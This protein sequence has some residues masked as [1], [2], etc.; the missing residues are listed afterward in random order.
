MAGKTRESPSELP[1]KPISRR[2]LLVAFAWGFSVFESKNV[3]T[4][5][6]E[7]KKCK[8]GDATSKTRIEESWKW[9]EN[10]VET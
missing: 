9:R 8:K 2:G 6:D 10:S 3:A 1:S 5:H 7:T 4:A